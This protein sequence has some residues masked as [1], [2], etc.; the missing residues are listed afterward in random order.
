VQGEDAAAVVVTLGA[1]KTTRKKCDPHFR[2]RVRTAYED[3]C[4]VCG[5]NGR[6][7]SATEAKWK[8]ALACLKWHG[9]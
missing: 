3:G 7:G 2:R 5:F 4:A 9:K 6:L 8:F 1:A